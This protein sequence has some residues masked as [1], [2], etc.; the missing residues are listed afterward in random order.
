MIALAVILLA[1]FATAST[2]A[3][4]R[5]GPWYAALEKPWWIPP[6]WLFPPAWGIMYALMSAAAFLVWLTGTGEARTTALAVYAVQLILNALWSPMFFGLKRMG[7][8]LVE[9]IALWL[10]VLATTLLFFGINYWAGLVFLPYLI[11]VSFASVL[12]WTMWRLNPNA[13][14]TA[15]AG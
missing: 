1:S 12:T 5:P 8:A 10:S 6:N 2:A 13:P 7:W 15:P 3:V 4:A 14:R 9:V 11:W